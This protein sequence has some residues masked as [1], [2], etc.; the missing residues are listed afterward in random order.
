M[1]TKRTL[2]TS[3]AVVAASLTVLACGGGTTGQGEAASSADGGDASA[4]CSASD[5]FSQGA[6][7]G[8]ACVLCLQAN[9]REQLDGY[10]NGC[11]DFIDCVCSVGA[12]V[13]SCAPRAS[14]SSCLQAAAPLGLC[15]NAS[16]VTECLGGDGGS[17]NG[18]PDATA[19]RSPLQAAGVLPGAPAEP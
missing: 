11:S 5:V 17:G 4:S 9:C 19:F 8:N 13:Q 6:A 3:A 7:A 18:A 15:I 14:D 10:A 12:A 2:A 1:R 16:C